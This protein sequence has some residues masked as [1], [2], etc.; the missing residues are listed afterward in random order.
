MSDPSVSATAES[1]VSN[2]LPQ[3]SLLPSSGTGFWRTRGTQL[4]EYLAAHVWAVSSLVTIVCLLYTPTLNYEFLNWDDLSYIVDNDLIRSWH[5]LN[6]WRVMTEP[7]TRNFAPLTIVTFLVEHTLWGQNSGGYH[8]TNVLL[9][10]N[11]VLM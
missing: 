7:V 2:P 9:H 11:L 1:V 10:T 5:P 6:L 8:A 4:R 3:A